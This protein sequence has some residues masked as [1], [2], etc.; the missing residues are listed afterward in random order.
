M[1]RSFR[2]GLLAAAAVWAASAAAGSEWNQE[3]DNDNK[4]LASTV[5]VT[6][7]VM[8]DLN[9]INEKCLRGEFVCGPTPPPTANPEHHCP[10]CEKWHEDPKDPK[11]AWDSVDIY[12]GLWG[13]CSGDHHC[14]NTCSCS[15][16]AICE[17]SSD[18]EGPECKSSTECSPGYMCNSYGYCQP[19]PGPRCHEKACVVDDGPE[20][21]TNKDCSHGEVCNHHGFCQKVVFP[22][23]EKN[24]DC[25]HGQICTNRGICKTVDEPQ[26]TCDSD[27][28]DGQICN[29]QRVCQDVECP[30]C[31]WEK[32][33]H[34]GESCNDSFCKP[35]ENKCKDKDDCNDDEVCDWEGKCRRGKQFRCR[36]D[37]EC[38]F[39]QIC[40][41]HGS[42]QKRPV[43]HICSSDR[44]C[45]SEDFCNAFGYC[46]NKPEERCESDNTCLPGEICSSGRCLP[47][48]DCSRDRDCRHGETC[49]NGFCV[50]RRF[51]AIDSDCNGLLNEVCRDHQCEQE[52]VCT[53]NVDCDQGEICCVEEECTIDTDCDDGTQTCRDGECLT[54]CLNQAGCN[55]NETCELGVCINQLGCDNNETCELG[56]CIRRRFCVNAARDCNLGEICLNGY[57]QEPLQDECTIDA[58]Y[59][60]LGEICEDG[61]CQDPL[62]NPECTVDADCGDPTLACVDSQCLTRCDDQTDCNNNETCNGTVCIRRRFCVNTATDCGLGEICLNNFYVCIAGLCQQGSVCSLGFQWAYYKLARS[63]SDLTTLPGTIPFHDDDP[64]TDETWPLLQFQPRIALTA[65]TPTV[66]GLTQTLGIDETCPPEDAIVYGTDTGNT[67]D[68]SIIQHIGYFV[69][70][71]AGTYTF[72]ANAPVPD[73]SLYV[74]FGDIARLTWVNA[75]ADLIADGDSTAVTNTY[76]RVVAP[77]DVGTYIPIRIL[78]VNPQDCGEFELTVQDPL[79]NVIVSREEQTTDG[80]FVS[81]CPAAN[82]ILTLDFAPLI[83]VGLGLDDLVANLTGG[84]TG[85]LTNLTGGLTNLTGGL[86]NLTG[87]LTN[88]TGGLG[89]INLTGDANLG[90]G[91]GINVTAGADLGGLGNLTGDVNVGGGGINVTTGAGLGGLGTNLTGGLLGGLTNLTGGLLTNLTGGGSS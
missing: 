45:K 73:Q 21:T 11:G 34:E 62:S 2:R 47:K 86:T 54:R 63:P 65:Q 40:D 8:V 52:R 37:S 22:D 43:G 27:C 46:E 75:N 64:T 9:D 25:K 89:G 59:C 49:E 56:V 24:W 14:P 36:V 13:G 1:S 15:S 61:Y 53:F 28:K 4:W 18:A 74:W 55:N 67:I 16:N 66:T 3:H 80:E 19:Q 79:G 41:I 44:D 91:G 88:L 23:C 6:S 39:G 17:H 84:L 70:A 76:L 38:K 42:C 48:I 26:C 72:S 71:Q 31:Q 69:P 51:C 12:H 77:A 90:G 81:N 50:F 85:G 30:K 68:Y 7:T 87:G 60:N 57:C 10:E 82:D 83:D 5:V 58:D 78:F 33:C 29:S 32:E 20:C 35:K